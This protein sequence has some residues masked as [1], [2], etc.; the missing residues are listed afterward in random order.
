MSRLKSINDVVVNGI[1]SIELHEVRGGKGDQLLWPALYDATIKSPPHI[2]TMV[3][4]E[5]SVEFVTKPPYYECRYCGVVQKEFPSTCP[6]CGA[7]M[8]I[9]TKFVSE[10]TPI[11]YPAEVGESYTLRPYGVGTVVRDMWGF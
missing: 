1:Q 7:P 3:I 4:P 10:A 6:Q 9:D 11:T 5:S 2:T 8:E